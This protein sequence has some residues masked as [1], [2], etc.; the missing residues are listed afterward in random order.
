[1]GE[2]RP[3][4]A[5]DIATV[6][7]L[8]QMGCVTKEE[9]GRATLECVQG[10]SRYDVLAA[11]DAASLLP[12]QTATVARDREL[13]LCRRRRDTGRR[14][15]LPSVSL[16]NL[17]P[18]IAKHLYEVEILRA[19]FETVE[20][21]VRDGTEMEMTLRA[22][23]YVLEDEEG[24]RLR[25]QVL[26]LGIPIFLRKGPG[27]AG[28]LLGNRLL[29]PDPRDGEALDRGLDPTDDGFRRWL[30]QGWIDLTGPRMKWWHGRFE[31]VLTSLEGGPAVSRNWFDPRRPFTA[32]QFLAHLYSISGG[33]RKEYM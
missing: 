23:S 3:Y 25:R 5:E 13:Q 29:F 26:S 32:G 7:A 1:S 4:A 24:A 22:C 2:N 17:G 27:E 6:T 8:G 16:G 12:T 11:I 15:P 19:A 33:H 28:L 9:V 31:Q 21:V 18:T 14:F 20:R 30:D 10:D